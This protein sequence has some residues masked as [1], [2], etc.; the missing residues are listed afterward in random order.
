MATLAVVGVV[1]VVVDDARTADTSEDAAFLRGF[2]IL[3]SPLSARV[4][5]VAFAEAEVV[6]ATAAVVAAAVTANDGEVSTMLAVF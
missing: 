6:T 5:L 2:R 1:V 3:P 4:V